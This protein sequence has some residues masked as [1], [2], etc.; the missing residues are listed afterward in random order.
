MT[1]VYVY[2]S[3]S[4]LS[5]RSMTKYDADSGNNFQMQLQLALYLEHILKYLE[6]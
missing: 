2:K 4:Q 3:G 5:K 1:T 6:N